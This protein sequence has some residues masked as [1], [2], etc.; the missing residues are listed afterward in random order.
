MEDRLVSA[1]KANDVDQVKTILSSGNELQ[2]IAST[3]LTA[4]RHGN[5]EI[6]SAFLADQRVDPSAINNRAI[7]V[8]ASKG[9]TDVVKLF[10]KDSRVDPTVSD[11]RP[12]ISAAS[13]S[14]YD[15][16]KLLLK[17]PRI[18]PTARNHEVL[19]Q[20]NVSE[21]IEL[22]KIL[23]DDGRV[24]LSVSE[25]RV[26]FT[27]FGDVDLTRKILKDPRVDP[28]VYGN[29]LIVAGTELGL[30]EYVKVL[31]EDPR[32]DLE[33]AVDTAS[34]ADCTLRTQGETELKNRKRTVE[35]LVDRADIRRE[36]T[37]QP[38]H[39][40]PRLQPDGKTLANNVISRRNDS[41]LYGVAV[42][43]NNKSIPTELVRSIIKFAYN[44]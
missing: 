20:A 18:D 14:H 23:V 15:T 6:V 40:N 2:D 34:E 13:N 32:V 19:R 33:R 41:I 8:A 25:N 35:W 30:T 22:I 43:D 26:L 27:V 29:E 37:D 11:N 38:L 7:V 1:I 42:L 10:L 3:F 12:L 39:K 31:A 16:V 24:D 21:D 44:V 5:I 28:S 4:V 36:R 17:D 9:H